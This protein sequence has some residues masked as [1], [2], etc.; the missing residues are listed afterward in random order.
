M[1]YRLIN[2]NQ[3]GVKHLLGTNNRVLT[4]KTALYI[5]KVLM[6]SILVAHNMLNTSE[7]SLGGMEIQVTKMDIKMLTLTCV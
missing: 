4:V 1:F 6:E 5:T 7:V 3:A 2:G